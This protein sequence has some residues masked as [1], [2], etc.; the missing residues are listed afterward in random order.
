MAEKVSVIIK[1][2]DTVI[3]TNTDFLVGELDAELKHV[4][5]SINAIIVDI[6]AN[7]VGKIRLDPSVVYVEYDQEAHV[8]GFTGED[9]QHHQKRLMPLSQT[10]PWG[11]QK[12]RADQVWPSGNKGTGIKVG[13]VDTGID[14]NHEDLKNNYKGGYNFVANTSDPFDD[15]GHGTHVAGTVAAL[16]NGIGVVGVAPE[17]WLY[18]IK[19]LD[20]QGSGSY[21][22]II[23]GLQWCLDNGMQVV[24]MSFGGSS[25]SQALS[26]I[27]DKLNNA[28]ILLVAAAGNSGGSSGQDTIGYPAKFPSVMAIAATDSNDAR[29]SF[30]SVGPELSVAAPGVNV[31]STVPTGSC[32]LCDTSGY[33]QLSGTSMST[34]H[35]VG[36]T[37]LIMKANPNMTNTDIRKA[38]ENTAIDLGNQ[39]HDDL[40]GWGRID[41]LNAV[42]QT[43]PPPPG[44]L[45]SITVSPASL[46]VNVGATGQLTATCKDQNNNTIICPSLTWVSDDTS[47]ATV[48]ST[49]KVSGIATGTAN[50]TA[51]SG[52]I[53]SNASSITVN[54][55]P[56]PVLTTIVLSPTNST[57]LVGKTVQLTSTCKDQNGNTI[58]CP[59]LTWT[60]NNTA[61]ATVDS[62]GKVTGVAVGTANVTANAGSIVSNTSAITVTTVVGSKFDVQVLGQFGIFVTKTPTGKYDASQACIIVCQA[63]KNM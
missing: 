9:I 29:A 3:K 62:T 45:A 55:A 61:V 47:V 8:L 50:V 6:P 35:V 20:S 39:G 23:S 14:Y 19:V 52:S 57:V 41:A 40:Y 33:K 30:S 54:I 12:I 38:I 43:P 46:S 53:V 60:S 4:I 27:C 28:G 31:P 56:I 36:T 22:N 42:N 34:P 44:P 26:D 18:A 58:T 11:V 25:F 17:A 2:K 10:T 15:Y 24:N 37:A 48:D 7:K 51:S 32:K 59:T 21:T 63:L 5:S 1:Y 49:G 16:D 13:I